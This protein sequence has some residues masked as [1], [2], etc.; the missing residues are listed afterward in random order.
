MLEDRCRR[1]QADV[2]RGESE[3]IG[4][5]L[6]RDLAAMSDLPAAPF[7]ACH[8]ATG[9]ISSQALACCKTNDDSVPVAYGHRDVWIRGIMP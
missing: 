7:D 2:L 9:R 6:A 5:R 3:T 8:Q 1:R 4:A